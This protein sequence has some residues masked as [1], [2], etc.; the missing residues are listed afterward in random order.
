[1]KPKLW[2]VGPLVRMERDEKFGATK[3][4]VHDQPQLHRVFVDDIGGLGEPN[5]GEFLVE[6]PCGYRGWVKALNSNPDGAPACEACLNGTP[7]R[8]V[9]QF[10]KNATV[11]KKFNRPSH[12]AGERG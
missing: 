6:T 9:H 12:E 1:M 4:F 2:G 3:R 11:E 7:S 8:W 10:P 5:A